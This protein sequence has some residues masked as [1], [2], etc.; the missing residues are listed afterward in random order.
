MAVINRKERFATEGIRF[1]RS[2]PDGTIPTPKRF[3]GF[4]NTVDLSRVLANNIA[5]LTIKIDADMPEV[6]QVDFSGAHNISRVTV[7]E[8]VTALNNA[9][10]TGLA[11]SKDIKTSR[12]KGSFGSGTAA[13]LAV[14]LT[15]NT[16]S[17][18]TIP[19][20]T[21]SLF[22]NGFSFI[23][24]VPSAIILPYGSDTEI[25][26]TRA[27]AGLQEN[28]PA[29]GDPV[30]LSTLNPALPGSASLWEGEISTATQGTEQEQD[31][32]IIQVVGPLAASLDF[33]QSLKH[34]GNGLEVISFFDDEAVSIGLPKDIKDKEEIDVE[35]AKGT[36]TRM[37]IGAML[38]GLS[39]VVTLKEKD[40]YLLE[41][42]QGGKLDR[43]T[44]AYNPPLSDATESP[45]FWAEIFSATYSKGSNKLSD[46]A[47]YE[48]IF[49]RSMVGIEGDV[50][51]EAKSWATYAFNLT[52]TE[53]TDENEKR[54]P[55]WEEQQI[56]LEAFDAL[57]VKGV[58][59]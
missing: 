32:K 27:S 5:P 46:V 33:G 47:A 57:K 18:Q 13:V 3:I 50:P 14:V 49:L 52:A 53:Y 30:D 9:G 17:A 22:L 29:V 10:F 16:G 42:I 2:N 48:R 38:Q 37:I 56:S 45:K 44:G 21:Y 15:N 39:P 8:A 20:G 41:M 12:L 36:I 19:E 40:Y 55:A 4:A 25:I 23:G 6:K 58:K 24:N 54:W 59:I 35:G 26:F 11:F 43:E 1:G 31:A 7:Q 51:I 28:L 34:G